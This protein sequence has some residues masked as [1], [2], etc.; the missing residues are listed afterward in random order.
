MTM[1]ARVVEAFVV[2]EDELQQEIETINRSE[3]RDR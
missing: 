1:N 2:L 3:E